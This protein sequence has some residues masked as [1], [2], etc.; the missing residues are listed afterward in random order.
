MTVFQ[1]KVEDANLT[2]MERDMKQA[3]TQLVHNLSDI[4]KLLII[5]M[6]DAE[7]SARELQLVTNLSQLKILT[8][9]RQYV[10][11]LLSYKLLEMTDPN[12]PRSP[13]QKYRLTKLG[14]FLVKQI[15]KDNKE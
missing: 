7:M 13:K 14:A 2:A 12:K 1:V 4:H 3:C 9:K 10:F 11:P 5:S 15:V 8:F 6:S